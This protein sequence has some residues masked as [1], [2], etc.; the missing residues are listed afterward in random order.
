MQNDTNVASD[1]CVM[2][3]TWCEPNASSGWAVVQ[4]EWIK[5]KFETVR[6]RR[7]QLFKS[8]TPWKDKIFCQLSWS[9]KTFLPFVGYFSVFFFYI[10]LSFMAV[11]PVW[12]IREKIFDTGVWCLRT[13]RALY[14]HGW[15]A[16]GN[17]SKLQWID[18]STSKGCVEKVRL[19][20]SANW[21]KTTQTCRFCFVFWV[22]PQRV[23]SWWFETEWLDCE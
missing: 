17:L 4:D 2:S 23:F 3:S 1:T 14:L 7:T 19:K 5:H 15:I 16:N 12:K 18:I 22:H 20:K 11:L 6:M 9:W 10:F 13:T 8:W 21:R